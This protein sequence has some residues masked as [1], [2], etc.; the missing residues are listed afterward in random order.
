MTLYFAS[1]QCVYHIFLNIKLGKG[2]LKMHYYNFYRDTVKINFSLEIFYQEQNMKVQKLRVAFC[3]THL[4]ALIR[5]DDLKNYP[6]IFSLISMQFFTL[7]P[8]MI[9]ILNKI[10][11]SF[12]YSMPKF[13]LWYNFAKNGWVN[14]FVNFSRMVAYF[15]N[16]FFCS[17]AASK[18]ISNLWRN[19]TDLLFYNV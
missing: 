19:F 16:F 2:Y 15:S 14:F 7:S 11:F 6:L 18:E 8:E 3:K 12:S 5:L 13:Q 4:S 9:F 10:H 1:S 17:I